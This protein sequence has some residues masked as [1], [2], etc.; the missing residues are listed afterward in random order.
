MGSVDLEVGEG[1][2]RVSEQG[3]GSGL[4]G[5]IRDSGRSGGSRARVSGCLCESREEKHL[6]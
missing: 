4:G 3:D 1:G 6:S 5:H 2:G